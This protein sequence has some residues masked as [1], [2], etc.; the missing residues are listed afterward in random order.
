MSAL[1]DRYIF[2]LTH[3][4]DTRDITPDQDDVILSDSIEDGQVFYRRSIKNDIAIAGEDFDWL[5]AIEQGA[6]RCLPIKIEILKR[7]PGSTPI[8]EFTGSF[9][10]EDCRF[11]V[12]RCQITAQVKAEDRYE[13]L[14]STWEVERNIL[15][16]TPKTQIYTSFR[17]IDD[18]DTGNP[19]SLIEYL[20]T[21]ETIHIVFGT[22]QFTD[23]TFPNTDFGWVMRTESVTFVTGTFIDIKKVVTWQREVTTLS[24]STGSFVPPSPGWVP[25]S[26]SNPT[27]WSRLTNSLLSSEV[28]TNFPVTLPDGFDY[29]LSE[30][31]F[32][33]IVNDLEFF[34]NAVSLDEVLPVLLTGTGLTLKSEFFEINETGDFPANDVYTDNREPNIFVM[35]RSDIL[36]YSQGDPATIAEISLKNFLEI[37]SAKMEVFAVVNGTELSTEHISFYDGVQGIDFDTLQ[38]QTSNEDSNSY[39]YQKETLPTGEAF[40]DEEEVKSQSLFKR[41]AF[42]YD[43]PDNDEDIPKNCLTR[44]GPV[45]ETIANVLCDV[46]SMVSNPDAFSDQGLSLLTA[47][48][49]FGARVL[50]SNG[51]A[52]YLMA[53]KSLAILRYYRRYF[54]YAYNL[55]EDVFYTFE[56]VKRYKQQTELTFKLLDYS[57][58]NPME[59]QKSK[60]GWG[61][62][63]NAEYSLQDGTLKITLL[64]D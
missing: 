35:Q 40:Y 28:I 57:L 16:G 4:G 27:K 49:A 9:F 50:D 42:S 59:E 53:A 24:Y 38:F 1:L 5:Y 37:L 7:V 10:T 17:T 47:T 46:Q 55:E 43:I 31:R 22:E 19:F 52:N 14:Y 20:T 36:R 29:K 15:D 58:F 18:P 39:T 44:P 25:A 33:W 62:V 54:K 13:A 48:D 60:L 32:A 34:D 11:T 26:A 3:N 45:R 56:S 63:D 8:L 64:H 23:S 41:F 2:R 51:A 12:D 21:T 6:N 30:R 61:A